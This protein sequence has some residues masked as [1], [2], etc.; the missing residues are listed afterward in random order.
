MKNEHEEECK[1]AEVQELSKQDLDA[2]A[3]GLGVRT[4]LS[5]AVKSGVQ[6][7]R[8]GGSVKKALSSAKEM[9]RGVRT[10]SH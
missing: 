2:V 3:G 1:T 7:L 5:Y 6:A 8:E 4:S 10:Y 9:Y